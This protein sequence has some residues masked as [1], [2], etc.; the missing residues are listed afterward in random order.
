MFII[1]DKEL[2]FLSSKSPTSE[3][4]RNVMVDRIRISLMIPNTNWLGLKT[5]NLKTS[6]TP[7]EI[8]NNL[9]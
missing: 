8:K 4:N 9:N 6:S 5:N 1:S 7:A 2:I 3:I